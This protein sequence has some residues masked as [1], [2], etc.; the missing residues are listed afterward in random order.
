MH[1]YIHIN[2]I[3]K[4]MNILFL[5]IITKKKNYL[6]GNHFVIRMILINVTPVIQITKHMFYSSL[7]TAN[8]QL[9]SVYKCL[10]HML[11]PTSVSLN[12]FH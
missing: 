11:F 12:L 5:G 6:T 1:I 9:V 2:S 8:F 7:S 3:V 4:N 10:I